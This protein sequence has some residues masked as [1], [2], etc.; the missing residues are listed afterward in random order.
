MIYERTNENSVYV[1]MVW[2]K[3][4]AHKSIIDAP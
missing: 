1:V 2:P 3:I 4:V